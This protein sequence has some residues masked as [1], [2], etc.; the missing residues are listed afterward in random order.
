[1][2]RDLIFFFLQKKPQFQTLVWEQE[3]KVG[4]VMVLPTKAR[5]QPIPEE[6]VPLVLHKISRPSLYGSQ[7]RSGIKRISKEYF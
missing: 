6:E 2:F 3:A 5:N 7:W 4:P 1:M